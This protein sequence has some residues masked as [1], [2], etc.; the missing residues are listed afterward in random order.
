LKLLFF[1]LDETVLRSNP[2]LIVLRRRIVGSGE[3]RPVTNEEYADDDGGGPIEYDFSDFYDP[4]LARLSIKTATPILANLKLIDEY[5]RRGYKAAFL[6]ARASEDAIKEGMREWLRE[7]NA[8][9]DLTVDYET[10]YLENESV[11]VNDR[12]R[13]RRDAP[14]ALKKAEVLRRVAKKFEEVILLG[15]D[16]CNLAVAEELELQNVKVVRAIKE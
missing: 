4:W 1:D 9:G 7:R 12:K 8:A 16:D 5:A 6:T 13:S 2:N 14:D 10:F 11:A 3:W 15:D